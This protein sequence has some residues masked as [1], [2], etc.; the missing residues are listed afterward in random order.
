MNF[1]V[2]VCV[3]VTEGRTWVLFADTKQDMLQWIEAFKRNVNRTE[4]LNS[5]SNSQGTIK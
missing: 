5:P 1:V 2:V 3:Q 4:P